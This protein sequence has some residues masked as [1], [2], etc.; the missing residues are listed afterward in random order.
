MVGGGVH[1]KGAGIA[2]RTIAQVGHTIMVFLLSMGEYLQDG[3]KTTEA[4]V[5]MGMNFII[6]DYLIRN[7]NRFGKG[8]FVNNLGRNLE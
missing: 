7:F 4:I 8:R 5:G 3:E 1:G 2:H 6:N